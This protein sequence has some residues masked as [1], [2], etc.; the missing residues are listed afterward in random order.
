LQK[1]D[2]FRKEYTARHYAIISTNTEV[3]EPGLA[4]LCGAFV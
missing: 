1:R 4:E 3:I 2:R